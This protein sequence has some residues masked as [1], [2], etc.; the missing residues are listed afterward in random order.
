MSSQVSSPLQ[1]SRRFAGIH[2]P[3]ATPFQE[4][5]TVDEQALRR[6]VVRWMQTPLTGLVVLGSNGEAPQLDDDEADLRGASLTAPAIFGVALAA[7]SERER[8]R[9]QEDSGEHRCGI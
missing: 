1:G 6:N 9:D 8:D 5:G 7:G 3:I 4:D 2:T